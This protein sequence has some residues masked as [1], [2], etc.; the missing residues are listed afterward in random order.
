MS[1]HGLTNTGHVFA[2]SHTML[3]G[4]PLSAH[5]LGMPSDWIFCAVL[6]G[7]APACCAN[8]V[9]APSHPQHYFCCNLC[10]DILPKHCPSMQPQPASTF[11]SLFLFFRLTV[12]RTMTGYTA[13][14]EDLVHSNWGRL[15]F[16]RESYRQISPLGNRVVG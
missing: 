5:D 8:L 11:H 3:P 10:C 16:G 1:P 12:Y 7:S 13:T 6:T 4:Q 15:V 14:V 9:S 2:S